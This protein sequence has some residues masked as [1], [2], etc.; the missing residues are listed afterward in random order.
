MTPAAAQRSTVAFIARMLAATPLPRMDA[1]QVRRV[2]R[3]FEE[4]RRVLP[5]REATA[6]LEQLLA[7]ANLRL[8][9][10]GARA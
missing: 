4:L 6:K 3:A 5:P 9:E 1:P 7:R 2:L 8:R 10:I